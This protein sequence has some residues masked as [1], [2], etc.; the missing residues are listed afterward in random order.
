[1]SKIKTLAIKNKKSPVDALEEWKKLPS[2]KKYLKERVS[3]VCSCNK[4]RSEKD[5]AKY[6]VSRCDTYSFSWTVGRI[7]S[8][9]L[10][11]YLADAKPRIIRDDWNIIEKHA[12]AIR[13][14]AESDSWDELS[15]ER[16][17]K[18]AYKKKEKEWKEAMDWLT[19]NWT[20][21][22]W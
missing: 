7:L 16:G 11:Q 14:Y 10:Y 18:Q 13:E 20:S 21:L 2:E 1:M 22:W 5:R 4:K 17:V 3:V 12:K 8:N 15:K 19:K 9:A 6:G